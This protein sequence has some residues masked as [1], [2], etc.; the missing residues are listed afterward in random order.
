MGHA[1]WYGLPSDIQDRYRELSWRKRSGDWVSKADSSNFIS[2]YATENPEEDFAE[3]FSAFIH[4]NE[5]LKAMAKD[6][7]KF[8][9]DILFPNTD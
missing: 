8:F 2:A 7:W 1:F 6:K 4:M 3:H 5:R 9:K